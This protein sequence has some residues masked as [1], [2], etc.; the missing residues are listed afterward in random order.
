MSILDDYDFMGSGTC[1]NDDGDH[2]DT[3]HIEPPA[4]ISNGGCATDC[5]ALTPTK[6]G[7]RG[8]FYDSDTNS[9]LCRCIFDSYI[10][11]DSIAGANSFYIGDDYS[12][13]I[14][15][16]DSMMPSPTF[17]CWSYKFT[18]TMSPTTAP[19]SSPVGNYLLPYN[20]IDWLNLDLGQWGTCQFNNENYLMISMGGVGADLSPNECASRCYSVGYLQSSGD[21]DPEY[22]VRDDFISHTLVDTLSRLDRL[23]FVPRVSHGKM[24]VMFATAT[25]TAVQIFRILLLEQVQT[26]EVC[27]LDPPQ[28]VLLGGRTV[29]RVLR[30]LLVIP[31]GLCPLS[32][33]PRAH[34]LRLRLHRQAKV[35]RQPRRA[36]HLH[37]RLHRQV[38]VQRRPRQA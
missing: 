9:P 6:L 7:Y 15:G 28:P 35:Q 32:R 31:A 21:W 29:C 34:H 4:P 13:P 18:T 33:Q 3:I 1:I 16:Y 2:W 8:F 26:A 14:T 36:H 10:D 22:R 27:L 37:L 17:H 5:E 24:V 25:L 12:G 23:L 38:K 20:E 30:I 11:V 19:T